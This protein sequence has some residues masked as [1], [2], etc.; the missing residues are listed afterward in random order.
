MD[1][2]S[3][4]ELIEL[5]GTLGVLRLEVHELREAADKMVPRDEMESSRKRLR[6]IGF[7]A[8]TV[9]LM[10]MVPFILLLRRA[11]G[12][13]HR[14]KVAADTANASQHALIQD[15]YNR[16]VASVNQCQARNAAAAGTVGL[17]E[18]LLKAESDS[19]V[20]DATTRERIA[21][22]RKVL[23]L[24]GAVDCTAFQ[25]QADQLIAQGASPKAAGQ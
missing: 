25:R 3:D 6:L 16:A 18:D 22:Y 9:L 7:I 10:T 1:R 20:Q 2:L 15:Q 8:V 14:A 23:G 24:A 5:L 17:I 12:A 13:A 11:D 19:P 21:A 4:D